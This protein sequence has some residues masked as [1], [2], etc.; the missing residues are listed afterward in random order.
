MNHLPQ[1]NSASK[2]SQADT[3]PVVFITTCDVQPE[4]GDT[5]LNRVTATS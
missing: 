5:V 2:C 3:R 4:H 1:S